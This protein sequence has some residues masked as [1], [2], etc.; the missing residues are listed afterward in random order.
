MISRNFSVFVFGTKVHEKN[1]P[2]TKFY[3][4]KI[5][6]GERPENDSLTQEEMLKLDGNLNSTN[7]I[8]RMD[9]RGV[10]WKVLSA[11]KILIGFEQVVLN[12]DFLEMA[13]EMFSIV[14]SALENLNQTHQL[15]WVHAN[16]GGKYLLFGGIPFPNLLE[17]T[18]VRRDKHRRFSNHDSKVNRVDER[19]FKDRGEY[20]LWWVEGG[21]FYFEGL[22]KEYEL[23]PK[24]AFT[25]IYN[26]RVWES[27]GVLSGYGSMKEH[28]LPYLDY[29][30]KYFDEK[31]P[32]SVVDLGCGDWELMRN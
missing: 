22:K 16:N 18:F 12:L 6:S 8:L 14:L 13:P 2:Q 15:I 21:G 32:K 26:F 24:K 11:T 9:V 5:A 7:M 17:V 31:K 30:Q 27:D 19:N 20:F 23:T 4:K 3:E 25:N 29:L 10:E 1:N 28:A